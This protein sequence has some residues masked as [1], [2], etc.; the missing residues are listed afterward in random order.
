MH[1]GH[2]DAG[3]LCTPGKLRR[4]DGAIVQPSRIFSE[5]GTATA[6]TV[7]SIRLSA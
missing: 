5:T 6:P 1:T 7:A 2:A 3:L 4:V